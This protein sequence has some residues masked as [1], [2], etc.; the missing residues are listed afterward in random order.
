MKLYYYA[1]S[2]YQFSYALP[3]YKKLGGTFVVAT[4]TR[5]FHLKRYLKNVAAFG[6]NTFRNTPEVKII[7]AREL[8]KL[9]G[10][11]F[12]LSNSILPEFDYSDC[13]TIF[14]EHGTSDKKYSSGRT[15]G[16]QKLA[17]YDYI[18]LSGPKNK[19][20]FTDI[21]LDIPDKKMVEIG[22]LRFDDFVNGEIDRD[23]QIKRLG[24]KD[25]SR[26]NIL[27]APT[28]RFGK[29]T[30]R[31]Y[32]FKFA[33]EI[34]KE[35]NLIIRPHFHDKRYADWVH[36]VSKLKG[37]KHL[38]FSNPSNLIKS[39][40]FFDFAVSDLMISDVSSVIYEY[41]ITLKPM[42]I[43]QNDFKKRHTMPDNMDIMKHTDI[44]D[45]SQDILAMINENISR[46]KYQEEYKNLLT[47]CF[48]STDGR[49]VDKAVNF[50]KKL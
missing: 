12:F 1:N 13:I 48:Y 15:I 34:T 43:I 30:L 3:V 42:I 17:K 31:Q 6:E 26:K 32:A 41:L 8:H 45:G 40:T 11:L 19:E 16:G 28:W 9:K 49:C 38:Y 24:I 20:R 47:S 33:N 50:L 37:I 18:F 21:D 25:T 46:Q 29:G 23:R 4:K 39:D 35:H 22:G 27:Y 5:Y 36:L 7:P 10:I 14:H 2:I 44:Y